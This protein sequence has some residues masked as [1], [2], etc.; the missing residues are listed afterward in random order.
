MDQ[1]ACPHEP[2]EYVEGGRVLTVC[3][4]CEAR[5]DPRDGRAIPIQ[6]PANHK[7]NLRRAA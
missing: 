3:A 6:P 2:F 5:L 7:P 4:V 1:N